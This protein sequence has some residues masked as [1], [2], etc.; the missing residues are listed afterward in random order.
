M[1]FM[2]F[3]LPFNNPLFAIIILLRFIRNVH[4]TNINYRKISVKY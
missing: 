3:L 1:Y 4:K 2:E